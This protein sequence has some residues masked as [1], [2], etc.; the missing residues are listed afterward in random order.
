MRR[1]S[2]AMGIL[3]AT[4]PSVMSLKMQL[5][6]SLTALL[7]NLPGVAVENCFKLTGIPP[8]FGFIHRFPTFYWGFQTIF[9]DVVCG[10]E[11]G[12]L[13]H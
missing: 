2:G 12:A 4:V 9:V 1:L 7:P 3:M 11:L 8:L 5:I 6:S 10:P 13:D